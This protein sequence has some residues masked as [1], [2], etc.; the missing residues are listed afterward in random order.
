MLT[1]GT[2]DYGREKPRNCA[3]AR[4]RTTADSRVKL[5]S[6]VNVVNHLDCHVSVFPSPF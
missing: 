1:A 4:V 5:G 2:D 3:K 6:I